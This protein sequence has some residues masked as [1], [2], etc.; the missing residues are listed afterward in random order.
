MFE[1]TNANTDSETSETFNL[2]NPIDSSITALEL[3]YSQNGFT[4]QND[5]VLQKEIGLQKL[6]TDGSNIIKFNLIIPGI[7]MLKRW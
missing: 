2:I 6:T 1:S 4:Y 3:N 5:V 7:S